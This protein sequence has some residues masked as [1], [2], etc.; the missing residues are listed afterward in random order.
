MHHDLI[1]IGLWWRTLV[2]VDLLA[3]GRLSCWRELHA[4]GRHVVVLAWR[5]S[6]WHLVALSLIV[7]TLLLCADIGVLVDEWLLLLGIVVSLGQW[8]LAVSVLAVGCCRA[9]EI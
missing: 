3:V 4:V 9:P 6:H 1:V 5:G 8:F 7:I 2:V